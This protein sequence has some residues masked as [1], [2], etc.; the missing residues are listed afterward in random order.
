MRYS[1]SII[2]ALASAPLLVSSAPVRTRAAS[3]NDALVFQFANVLEQ[4]ETKFYAEGIAKFKEA[5][6][7]AAG[8]NSPLVVSEVL[9]TIQADE[10][11]HT[12]FIQQ[13]LKDN[14]A[15]ALICDFDFSTVLTD[16]ATMAAVARKVEYVGVSAYL[17]GATLIDDPI[18]LDAAASILTIEARHQTILNLMAGTGAAI[19]QAF[20]IPLTPQEILSIAGP[21]IKQPCDLG[22]TPTKTLSVTNTDAIQEGTKLTFSGEGVEGS[23]QFC[24]M[25]TGGMPFSINLPIED[26]VVPPGVNGPVAIWI[27]SDNN[28]LANNVIDR[29]VVKQVAG[30][31]IIFVDSKPEALGQLVRGSGSGSGT[32]SASS[33]STTTT[34]TPEEAAKIIA[35]ASSTA[36]GSAPAAT[37]ESGD[38]SSSSGGEE[39]SSG[40]NGAAAPPASTPLPPD[41]KG[42][43]PDGKTNVLGLSMVPRPAASAT[44]TDSAASSSAAPTSTSS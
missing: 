6:F 9:T 33:S 26:C 41:F 22:V 29:D 40:A 2:A 13:A 3:A 10:A 31:D 1:T 25:I 38:S 15:E 21:F 39:G 7:T 17:G 11:A 32:D 24:N 23:G 30:P 44:P 14:G 36:G 18:F 37:G 4:L 43:S 19:P 28:P 35:A 42:D 5:D 34:I 27:T 16:V 12:T 8:F 20:D